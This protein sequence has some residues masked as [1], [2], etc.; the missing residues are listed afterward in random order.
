LAIRAGRNRRGSYNLD[1]EGH[2]L[3][4]HVSLIVCAAMAGV[5]AETVLAGTATALLSAVLVSYGLLFGRRLWLASRH[6]S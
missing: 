5:I 6:S 3:D 1:E 2:G 4:D